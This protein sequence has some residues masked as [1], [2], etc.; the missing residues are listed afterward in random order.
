MKIVAEFNLSVVFCPNLLYG[1]R[2]P[3]LKGLKWV[4]VLVRVLEDPGIYLYIYTILCLTYFSNI[5]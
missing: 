5:E 3:N 2:N 1:A 4:P